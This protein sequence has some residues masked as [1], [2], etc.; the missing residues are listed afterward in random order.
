MLSRTMTNSTSARAGSIRRM[1]R[2]TNAAANPGRVFC[3]TNGC[4]SFLELDQDSGL[5]TCP[6]CGFTRRVS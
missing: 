6:I 1:R 2:R 3:S 5:A 4:P